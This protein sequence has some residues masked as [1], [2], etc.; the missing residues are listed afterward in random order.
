MSSGHQT[1]LPVFDPSLA[2]Y[3]TRIVSLD[4]VQDLLE[5]THAAGRI[6]QYRRSMLRGDLFPPVSVIPL[7]G[8]WIIA[9]GHKRFN[10]YR[11][12]GAPAILVEVWTPRRFLLDQCIQLRNNFKKNRAIVANVFRDRREA[13]RLLLATLGHWQR[14]VL[15]LFNGWKALRD[16]SKPTPSR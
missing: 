2:E 16:K 11:S 14:V 6:D 12:F 3:P 13:A 8:R 4:Q 15:S 1:H 9:D 5:V 10:A 7:G